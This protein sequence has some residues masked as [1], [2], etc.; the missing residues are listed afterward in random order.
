MGGCLG[1]QMVY[2]LKLY[3]C[4]G[5]AA[6]VCCIYLYCTFYNIPSAGVCVGGGGLRIGLSSPFFLG[7][8]RK[9]P[10]RSIWCGPSLLQYRDI[11]RYQYRMRKQLQANTGSLKKF[12]SGHQVTSNM[13]VSSNYAELHSIVHV[14]YDLY[15]LFCLPLPLPTPTHL[16]RLFS[17]TDLNL[18]F[19]FYF[20]DRSG[21]FYSIQTTSVRRW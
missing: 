2:M 12:P 19:H 21:L 14:N 4:L 6:H 3:N 13:D 9:T 16:A 7:K 15:F 20:Q 17:I 18:L 11:W 10:A 8:G 5:C 1:C